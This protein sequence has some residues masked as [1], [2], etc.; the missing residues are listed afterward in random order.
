MGRNPVERVE[1][2]EEYPEAR[3][4][5]VGVE[6]TI[7][8]PS[9]EAAK[10]AADV[11]RMARWDWPQLTRTLSVAKN[12]RE[13]GSFIAGYVFAENMHD[14]PGLR[15]SVRSDQLA[16]CVAFLVDAGIGVV[17]FAHSED[18]DGTRMTTLDVWVEGGADDALPAFE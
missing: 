8:T 2:G 7:D 11:V 3:A 14:A 6:V 10:E 1:D 9:R 17:P 13:T 5:V 4:G 12:G 15:V 16:G 18:S